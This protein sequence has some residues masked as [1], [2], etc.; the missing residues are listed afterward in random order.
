M[1]TGR[2]RP[3]GN[4]DLKPYQYSNNGQPVR[5]KILSIRFTPDEMDHI[6]QK[7]GDRLMEVC[8]T[9]LLGDELN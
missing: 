2:G 1:G 4:P 6:K 5:S 8:R 7:Y 9:M 3:G